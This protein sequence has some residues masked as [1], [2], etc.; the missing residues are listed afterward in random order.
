M[1]SSALHLFQAFG[2]EL[3]YMIVDAQ[4]LDVLPIADKVMETF[5]GEPASDVDLGEI[6]LSNEL[7]MHVIEFK[8]SSPAP[9]LY[10][11]EGKFQDHVRQ[12]NELLHPMGAML[13]PGA[14]HPLMN[15]DVETRI[16]EHEYTEV[17]HTF[18]RIFGC[19]GHGWSNLQSTHINLPFS[20]D[21]E[22]S[23]LHAAIR[24]IL[25]I[26]P[27]I[28]ASSPIVEGKTKLLDSRMDFYQRN[29]LRIPSITAGVIP[30]PVFTE[31]D[32]RRRIFQRIYQDIAPFDPE[33][34][35]QH[36]WLNARGAIA[37]FD[38]GAIE[39]RVLDIQ[40]CP[41]ADVAIAWLITRVLQ[42]LVQERWVSLEEQKS[43]E[44]E[45]LR[46]LFQICIAEGEQ[47]V[48][49]DSDYL[50]VFHLPQN[51]ACAGELWRYLLEQVREGHEQEYRHYREVF[52]VL[53]GQGTL[54]RRI[55]K[56]LNDCS[57]KPQIRMVYG[58][59]CACLQEGK[60]F[61]NE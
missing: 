48:I 2:V 47:A 49:C 1:T 19:K 16:W 10:Q 36:E 20:G 15:P 59:L 39:I 31:A 53:M 6:S 44:A 7:V 29:S 33:G 17:Y 46:G 18:D 23:R 60:M 52:E 27:A 22:F 24:L 5:T 34:I 58:E 12:V 25:P 14:M 11:L 26:L 35:M 50:R 51:R 9:A 43:W 21:E 13:M 4:T 28:A 40:E 37:R 32:Y 61:V 57:N 56:R 41:R 55:L 3:E 38:R 54:A 45:K 30:E 42:E 8:T